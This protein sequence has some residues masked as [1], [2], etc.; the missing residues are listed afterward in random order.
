MDAHMKNGLEVEPISI[1]MEGLPEG[2]TFDDLPV[3]DQRFI[4]ASA[5]QGQILEMQGTK[6]ALLCMRRVSL[7]DTY[8]EALVVKES[9]PYIDSMIYLPKG[10]TGTM[11]KNSLDLAVYAMSPQTRIPA[12]FRPENL[13][14]SESKVHVPKCT[15]ED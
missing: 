12:T 13:T 14:C 9:C 11:P 7:Y 10:Y 2:I 15:C 6:V 5:L 4:M 1:K 3:N 8:E